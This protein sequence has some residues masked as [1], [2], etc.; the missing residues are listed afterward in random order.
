MFS[1]PDI[2]LYPNPFDNLI[3][4]KTTNKTIQKV[5]IFNV[6]GKL[7]WEEKSDSSAI[8]I[9]PDLKQNQRYHVKIFTEN[10]VEIIK[11]HK[12]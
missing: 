5:Q 3:N 12:H 1:E 8:Q 6:T 2:I 7:V 11:I 4:I 9:Y 10:R